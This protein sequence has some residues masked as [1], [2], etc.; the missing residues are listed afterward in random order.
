MWK[1]VD[2]CFVT[3]KNSPFNFYTLEVSTSQR[4][5]NKNVKSFFSVIL[6]RHTHLLTNHV[7]RIPTTMIKRATRPDKCGQKYK[8][9]ALPNDAIY[10]PLWGRRHHKGPSTTNNTFPAQ[11]LFVLDT[12]HFSLYHSRHSSINVTRSEQQQWAINS[13]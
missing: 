1:I 6:R 3:W 4:V 9:T 2:I 10:F 13:C 7:T 5:I 11:R 12:E 8:D